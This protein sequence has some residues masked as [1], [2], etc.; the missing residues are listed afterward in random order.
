VLT[1]IEDV[2]Q[3]ARDNITFVKA[4][5]QHLKQELVSGDLR[6]LK[7][8]V[9]A[10]GFLTARSTREGTLILYFTLCIMLSCYRPNGS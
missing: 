1:T 4:Y 2:L 7:G 3:R 6:K 8:R 5:E 9:V 10:I